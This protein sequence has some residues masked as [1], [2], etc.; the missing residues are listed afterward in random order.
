MVREPLSPPSRSPKEEPKETVSIFER[1]GH[2]YRLL[3][4]ERKRRARE[5]PL[6]LE[7]AQQLHPEDF[8]GS[9][10]RERTRILDL[11][12]GNGF[13]ARL[14]AR[15]GYPVL[16]L[17]A[18]AAMLAQARRPG[19]S[20]S[21]QYRQADLLQPIAPP[22]DAALTLLLGNTLSLFDPTTQLSPVLSH[23]AHATRPSG[24]VLCQILNYERLRS[25]GQTTVTRHGHIRRR[26]T[27]LTKTLQ[28]L[29]DGRVL[30]MFAAAQERPGEPGWET[31]AESSF[32]H[33]LSPETL[34]QTAAAAGLT[35]EGEWGGLD[36]SPFLPATS[37]DY[38]A[39]FRKT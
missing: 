20:E 12:C 29:E 13:H 39:L 4:D 2:V 31:L 17:D 37:S 34:Q 9:S 8:S 7:I 16:A 25:L 6:L 33:A 11:A 1:M 19:A 27:V 5:E 22:P 26:E 24:K 36:K 23:A 28:V 10:A 38:V 15:A 32:L 18:S 30:L 21:V 14:F 35:L 3:V